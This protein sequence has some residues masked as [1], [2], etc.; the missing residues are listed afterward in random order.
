[1]TY[2][3]LATIFILSV[4]IKF[5]YKIYKEKINSFDLAIF[6]MWICF[7]L[8]LENYCGKFITRTVTL[9]KYY[10]IKLLS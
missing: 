9:L 5:I 3:L 1:M 4:P 2:V 6:A 8:Y 7:V 10:L